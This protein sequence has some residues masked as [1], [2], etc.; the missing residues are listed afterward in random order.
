KNEMGVPKLLNK[1]ER[2]DCQIFTEEKKEKYLIRRLAELPPE[3]LEYVING[4]KE[5]LSERDRE[6]L[7]KIVSE[8]N[9]RVLSVSEIKDLLGKYRNYLAEHFAV[10]SLGIFG[11][12]A[13]GEQTPYSDIDIIVEFFEGKKIGFKIFGLKNFLEDILGKTVDIISHNSLKEGIKRNIEK[14]VVYLWEGIT[15]N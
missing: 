6:R 5:R 10:K 15:E 4:L 13:R 7:I 11:S 12:Y 8:E 9:S 3:K 2:K 14:E 1:R